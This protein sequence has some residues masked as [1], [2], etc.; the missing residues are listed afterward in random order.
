MLMSLFLLALHGPAVAPQAARPAGDDPPVRV[1]FNSD[2][3]YAY[4]DRAKVYAKSAEDGYLVVLR[5]DGAGRVRVLFPLDP[6][7]D[8]QV[9][10]GKK[11]ELKGRGGQEAFV[12]D[13]SSG[14]GTVLAAISKS[15][16]RVDQF[17]RNGRWDLQ[18][19]SNQP[20]RADPESGLLELVQRMT[21]PSEHFNYDVSAYV[22]SQRYARGL[23]P[24]PYS[25]DWPGWWGYDP[26]WAYTPRVGIGLQ[27]G[28]RRFY[29]YRPGWAYR[30]GWHR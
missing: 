23:Y 19:L 5:A 14:R 25:Y 11:Y 30:G 29:G 16:F 2:G 12:A 10:G 3:N 18:A 27:F 20:V 9:T 17:A 8:Q 28:P 7:G 1:W 24:Y 21:P 15:P 4:G 6:Q 22:I 13:D 26:L